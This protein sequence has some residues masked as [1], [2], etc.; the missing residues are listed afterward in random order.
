MKMLLRKHLLLILLLFPLCNF[1]QK[2][3]EVIVEDTIQM[4]ANKFNYMVYLVNPEE[5]HISATAMNSKAN[6]LEA[7]QL[8]TLIKSFNVSE[9]FQSDDYSIVPDYSDKMTIKYLSF[10]NKKNL[11][12][13]HTALKEY[14]NVYANLVNASSDQ[15]EVYED[16][17]IDKLLL[18]AENKAR[19]FAKKLGSELD[20]IVELSESDDYEKGSSDLNLGL[21]LGWTAY[22]PA[23]GNL[24]NL[25]YSNSSGKIILSKKLVVK[26]RLK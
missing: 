12:A 3:V 16:Q 18:K 1:A 9:T 4:T 24:Q 19:L 23:F 13:F 21:E 25:S 20:Q 10:Q 8:I 6:N 15:E 22:Y 7:E 2:T 5:I 26:Y 14:E 11:Q 17:L